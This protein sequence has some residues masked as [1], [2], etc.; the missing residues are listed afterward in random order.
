MIK[1][2]K[3]S[4]SIIFISLAGFLVFNTADAA[5]C[6][7]KNIIGNSPPYLGTEASQNVNA[8][9]GS[10]VRITVKGEDGCITQFAEFQIYKGSSLI[11]NI[12]TQLIW[13]S[14][15]PN[16]P[17]AKFLG[18]D[19][20][21][22]LDNGVY[23]V[24]LLKVGNKIYS[25]NLSSNTLTVQSSQDCNLSKLSVNP[26][27]GPGGQP[28]Q[29]IVEASGTCEGWGVTINVLNSQ[30]SSVFKGSEQKFLA[31][32]NKLNWTWIPPSPQGAQA[33][34]KFKANLGSQSLTSNNFIITK[35]GGEEP[36]PD[37]E[38]NE[39][40]FEIENPIEAESLV[41]LAK[42]IGK[43]IFQIAIPIAVIIIIYAGILFLTSGGD[44]EKVGK[45]RKA[46]FYAV[47]GLAIILIGQGFFTLIKSILEL[48][49]PGP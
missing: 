1:K 48:G 26:N 42:A 10:Q 15:V 5:T 4:I 41:D 9:K 17:D 30:N 11:K 27:G 38:D 6:G 45:A 44:K 37:G 21:V 40:I 46:L 36:P 12:T 25:S 32:S 29:L 2:L 14:S 43:F 7:S 31:G 47:V 20:T 33:V 35:S 18:G 19:W 39:V 49:G 34:Y 13:Q 28:I 16:Q 23:S 22:D 24:K 8:S 3:I